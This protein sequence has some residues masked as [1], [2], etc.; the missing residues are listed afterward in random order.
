M[1]F[2]QSTKLG[3]KKEK[4]KYNKCTNY[5]KYT[6]GLTS[7]IYHFSLIAWKHSKEVLKS[8]LGWIKHE[9]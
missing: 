1:Q 2:F 7:E 6:K 9:N 4:F 3:K 5:I 8:G